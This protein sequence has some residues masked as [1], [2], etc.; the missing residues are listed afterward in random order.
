MRGG[1]VGSKAGKTME[2]ALLT[3]GCTDGD[4]HTVLSRDNH[5][6]MGADIVPSS[7]Q[8]LACLMPASSI[9]T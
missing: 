4:I 5:N 6:G 8:S 9:K 1:A 3:I 7:Y 2:D